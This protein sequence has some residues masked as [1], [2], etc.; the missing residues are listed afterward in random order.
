MNILSFIQNTCVRFFY[1][2]SNHQTKKASCHM[3]QNKSVPTHMAAKMNFPQKNSSHKTQPLKPRVSQFV[4]T[5]YPNISPTGFHNQKPAQ[6]SSGI[7]SQE[8]LSQSLQNQIN[9][10]EKEQDAI[11]TQ[12]AR[13]HSQKTP[14]ISIH[15]PTTLTC[16]EN[17][18]QQAALTKL[19]TQVKNISSFCNQ[20]MIEILDLLMESHTSLDGKLAALRVEAALIEDDVLLYEHIEHI[21]ILEKV[22]EDLHQLEAK[23][24]GMQKTGLYVKKPSQNKQE[25][26]VSFLLGKIEKLNQQK[27]FLEECKQSLPAHAAYDIDELQQLMQSFENEREE[28]SQQ[29]KESRQKLNQAEKVANELVNHLLD[30]AEIFKDHS[31]KLQRQIKSPTGKLQIK[32]QSVSNEET[33]NVNLLNAAADVAAALKQLLE[34]ASAI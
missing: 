30:Y 23:F 16:K 6:K 5:S 25:A 19:N 12:I 17:I 8:T 32:I 29:T 9:Q 22:S 14:F 15:S 7:Q 13:K 18:E 33:P 21:A 31:H 2:S 27:Q 20:E 28:N 11:L 3:G 1:S 10:L 4:P 34:V 26:H 24:Q